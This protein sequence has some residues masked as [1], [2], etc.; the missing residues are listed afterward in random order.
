MNLFHLVKHFAVPM[1]PIRLCRDF[2][3]IYACL[4]M[5]EFVSLLLPIKFPSSIIGLLILFVLLSLRI[6]PA[7]WVEFGAE[8][9]LSVI[10]LF[11]IPPGVSVIQ[12]LTDIRLFGWQLIVSLICAWLAMVVT[13]TYLFQWMEKK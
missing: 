8:K 10:A 1:W 12:D 6:I 4:M 3:I 2:V 5:G 9:L 7:R 13:I 11:F